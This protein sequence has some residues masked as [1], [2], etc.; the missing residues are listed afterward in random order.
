MFFYGDDLIDIKCFFLFSGKRKCFSCF[1]SI[2]FGAENH[3]GSGFDKSELLSTLTC[4]NVSVPHIASVRIKS[5]RI[6]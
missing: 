1:D 2:E 6:L 5:L 4:T 3:D